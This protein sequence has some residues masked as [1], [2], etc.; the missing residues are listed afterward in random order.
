MTL[1]L[2]QMKLKNNILLVCFLFSLIINGMGQKLLYCFQTNN[3]LPDKCLVVAELMDANNALLFTEK[4]V[5]KSDTSKQIVGHFNF[6]KMMPKALTQAKTLKVTLMDFTKKTP[7]DVIIYPDI[8][9][10]AYQATIN[11]KQSDRLLI[12]ENRLVELGLQDSITF[13]YNG[14]LVTYGVVKYKGRYWL[15]RNSGAQRAASTIH[16]TLSYGDLFQWGREADGHQIGENQIIEVELAPTSKQPNHNGYIFSDNSKDWNQNNK[17]VKRWYNGSPVIEISTNVCPLG[18]HVPTQ[19]EWVQTLTGWRNREDA[20][21][22]PLKIPAF[23]Y[24]DSHCFLSKKSLCT[25]LWSST[26]GPETGSAAALF[27]S[28]EGVW[29][30]DSYYIKSGY[31][32]RCII[33]VAHSE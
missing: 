6:G 25:F 20:F 3:K 10:I 26:P 22:S 1:K 13:W 33:D 8:T 2:K 5:I 30:R 27:L 23:N 12:L 32:V 17:W 4:T 16:D 11:K 31:G 15:D 24:R 29:V 9:A 28:V 19:L 18:W 7:L 14:E 21:N